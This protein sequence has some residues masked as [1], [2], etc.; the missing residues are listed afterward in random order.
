MWQT[1][2]LCIIE[3]QSLSDQRRLVKFVCNIHLILWLHIGKQGKNAQAP[4][5]YSR[6]RKALT[7]WFDKC[8]MKHA[9]CFPHLSQET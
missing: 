3:G 1:S 2:R 6:M 7:H 5:Q 8:Y 4:S 9:R